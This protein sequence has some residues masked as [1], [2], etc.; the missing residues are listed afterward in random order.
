MQLTEYPL[1]Q[2]SLYKHVEE[3][4]VT[5]KL[6]KNSVTPNCLIRQ[7]AVKCRCNFLEC[8]KPQHAANYTANYHLSQNLSGL[9]QQY[10]TA[11]NWFLLLPFLE[12]L[13]NVLLDY[14]VLETM[15]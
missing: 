9:D 11:D 6:F 12:Q 1:P 13:A 2:S 3:P 8:Q 5:T 10:D 4:T 7:L 14:L 15:T